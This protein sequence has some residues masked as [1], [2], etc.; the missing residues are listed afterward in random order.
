MAGMGGM[1]DVQTGKPTNHKRLR[2]TSL[3]Q[4]TLSQ[5]VAGATIRGLVKVEV[6]TPGARIGSYPETSPRL[7]T[8]SQP[9]LG[10]MTVFACTHI[11]R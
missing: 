5:T 7:G 9:L 10:Y 6:H 3:N 1:C 11:Q 4:A 8:N 2:P